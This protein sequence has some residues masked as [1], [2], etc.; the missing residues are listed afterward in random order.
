VLDQ[1]SRAFVVPMVIWDPAETVPPAADGL[2][3]L[4]D[5]ESGRRRTLWLRPRVRRDWEDAVASR[6]AELAALFA[7]RGMRP[8]WV[9]H[10]FDAEAVSRYFLEAVA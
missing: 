2:L 4:R 5:A 8:L 10:G 1:L 9:P 6:R 3:A 7:T